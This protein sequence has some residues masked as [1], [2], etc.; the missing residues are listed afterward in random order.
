MLQA[1]IAGS[2]AGFIAGLAV[3]VVYNWICGNGRWWKRIPRRRMLP[4][5]AEWLED[6]RRREKT[7]V[8]PW[9]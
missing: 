3:N 5:D 8:V 1:V 9:Y 6:Y 2:I 7:V 4:A